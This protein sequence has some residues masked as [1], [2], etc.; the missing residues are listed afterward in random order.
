MPSGTHSAFL[1]VGGLPPIPRKKNFQFFFDT[2]WGGTTE[3]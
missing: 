1:L 2:S 3:K